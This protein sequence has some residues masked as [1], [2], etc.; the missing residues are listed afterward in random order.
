MRHEA[1][2]KRLDVPGHDAA[3][4]TETE[5]GRLLKGTAVFHESGHPACLSY[6]VRL[7]SDWSAISGHVSGF[8]GGR[9][10][11][12]RIERRADGWYLNDVYQ[13]LGELVDLD[14][15]FT[16]ATNMPQLRRF[17]LADGE[18][19]DVNVAWYDIGVERLMVLPQIY[20]RIDAQ[21]YAYDSPT[22]GLP[23]H[24]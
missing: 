16:P 15:G 12:T 5:A 11:D 9:S 10:V 23:R 8:H 6:E 17:G 22:G 19:A 1:L 18:T 24:A 4:I 21:S 13:S 20:R 7:A 14:F 3:D 2:W